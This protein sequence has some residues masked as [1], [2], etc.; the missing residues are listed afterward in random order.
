MA[1]HETSTAASWTSAFDA[2]CW[3]SPLYYSTTME[4]DDNN[5][6]NI[7]RSAEPQKEDDEVLGWTLDAAARGVAVMGTAVFVSSELLRLAKE[8]A[9]CP[10]RDDDDYFWDQI[11]EC[12]ARVYGMRPTSILSNIVMI[13]GLFSA[14]IM[15]LIGS[16]IDHTNYRRAVGGIS[17]ACLAFLMLLQM[18]VMQDY[19]HIAAILQI[20]VAFSYTIHLCAVY[21]YLPELTSDHDVLVQYTAQFSAAQYMGSVSF[22]LVMVVV[23]STIN[24]NQTYNVATLSQSVAFVVCVSFFGYAWTRLF[25]ERPASQQVPPNRSLLSSGFWKIY[26]TGRTIL[27]E[28]DAIKWFLA[29]AALTNAAT[30]TFSTIAITYM[31]E[32]LGFS[33]KENGIAILILLLF[34]VPGTRLAAWLTS[35]FNPIRSLQACLLLWIVNTGAAAYFLQQPDQQGLAYFFAMIWGLA[36]G[37]VYPTEK[38]LYVTIIPRGQEAE[39]MGCYICAGQMLAW[40]PPLVFTIMNESGFSMRVG[41][42]AL[43]FYFA[44]SFVILFLV[45]D[46]EDAVQHAREID[47]GKKEF[48]VS[49]TNGLLVG[50]YEQWGS[51]PVDSDIASYSN[52][53]T[54][55]EPKHAHTKHQQQPPPTESPNRII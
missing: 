26:K 36:L 31:T 42:F 5:S 48:A 23:L 24:R 1:Q 19:W 45:G 43:T 51:H 30:T 33:A 9:E 52:E 4:N 12:D 6:N 10:E 54:L 35:G 3:I 16:I 29:A 27:K 7:A 15:P 34:G 8:A 49:P 21:A 17:A 13:V 50:C 2:A 18:L 44:I 47:Q 32:Q 53:M 40:L 41:L 38:T 55:A 25:R 28:H 37:W 39:L 22:L 46:Y 20:F 11:V 14:V